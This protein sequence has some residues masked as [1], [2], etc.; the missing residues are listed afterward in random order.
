MSGRGCD[1][2]ARTRVGGFASFRSRSR[3]ARHAP[4]SS[5]FNRRHGNSAIRMLAMHYRIQALPARAPVHAL[6]SRVR[7]F[8]VMHACAQIPRIATFWIR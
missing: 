7:E 3:N 2:Y 4:V 8:H 5:N 1:G 6:P